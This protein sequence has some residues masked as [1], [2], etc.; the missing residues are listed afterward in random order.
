MK[1]QVLKVA[2]VLFA[3]ATL[4]PAGVFAQ[5]PPPEAFE[6][7]KDKA[8]GDAVEIQTP[9]GKTMEAT[10]Q[11]MQ[12]KLVAMPAGGPPKQ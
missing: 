9:D 8:I 1:K 3:A 2:I 10:C 11:D 4:L 12:G 7:C 6:L 5:G